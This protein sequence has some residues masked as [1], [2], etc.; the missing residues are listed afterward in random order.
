MAKSI[1]MVWGPLIARGRPK[2][3]LNIRI[4]LFKEPLSHVE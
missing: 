2:N 4:G 3:I 1:S